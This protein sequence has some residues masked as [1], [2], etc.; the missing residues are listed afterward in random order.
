MLLP[1]RKIIIHRTGENR[2]NGASIQKPPFTLFPPV[3]TGSRHSCKS[4]GRLPLY[5]PPYGLTPLLRVFGL[6][7][8]NFTGAY[9]V[10]EEVQVT[11]YPSSVLFVVF[12]SKC[13]SSRHLVSEHT[14]QVTGAVAFVMTKPPVLFSAVS[15]KWSGRRDT[16]SV[17][18][19]RIRRHLRRLQNP[20]YPL[21]HN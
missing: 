12:C 14:S 17:I 6:S 21:T 4:R 13:R 3:E 10:N 11:P 8:Q 20:P 19:I 1:R 5:Q 7:P 2:G 16:N 15:S 9:K 18:T